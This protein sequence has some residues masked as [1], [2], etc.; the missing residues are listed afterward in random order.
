[1]KDP[2]RTSSNPGLPFRVA[3]AQKRDPR[4]SAGCRVFQLRIKARDSVGKK[5]GM[6][7]AVPQESN[8]SRF[9]YALVAGIF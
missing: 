5:Q 1:M 6:V 4:R 2:N 3:S 9:H 8:R 7:L